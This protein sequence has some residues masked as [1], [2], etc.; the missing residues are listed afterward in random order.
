[1]K[2]LTVLFLL[3]LLSCCAI[4]AP[5]E[6]ATGREENQHMSTGQILEFSLSRLKESIDKTRQKN[7]RLAFENDMLRKSIHDLKRQKE[8]L[9]G[10]KA[11]LYGGLPSSDYEKKRLQSIETG[12][13]RNREQRTRELIDIFQRDIARLKE[14]VR[15]IEDSLEGKEFTARRQMFA[16]KADEGREIL[17]QAQKKLRSLQQKNEVPEEK[18]KALKKEQGSLVRE[19]EN[20]ER[21]LRGF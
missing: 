20:L 19:I 15:I 14:E 11:A 5:L 17:A 1:M 10:K 16:Q 18:I 7:D 6:A 2:N 21:K 3:F 4:G 8:F 9:A 12:S 13:V